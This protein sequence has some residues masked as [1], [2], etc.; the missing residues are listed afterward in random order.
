MVIGCSVAR[1]RTVLG[2]LDTHS[3]NLCIVYS[4]KFIVAI[5]YSLDCNGQNPVA[6]LRSTSQ[7]GDL[8]VGYGKVTCADPQV[9]KGQ[10]PV[11]GLRSTG[12]CSDLTHECYR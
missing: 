11:T 8:T 2:D 5:S 3:C 10:V 12:Q 4:C 6:G 7:C 1:L 9:I